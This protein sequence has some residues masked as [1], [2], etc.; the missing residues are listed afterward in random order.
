MVDSMF[1]FTSLLVYLVNS[2]V[3]E[4]YTWIFFLLFYLIL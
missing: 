4:H 3:Y 1:G 2:L